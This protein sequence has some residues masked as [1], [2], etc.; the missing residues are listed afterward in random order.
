MEDQTE[1]KTKERPFHGNYTSS[2]QGERREHYNAFIPIFAYTAGAFF[3]IMFFIGLY[4][5]GKWLYEL[6]K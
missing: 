4:T 1:F 6:L 5:V 2:G 3:G